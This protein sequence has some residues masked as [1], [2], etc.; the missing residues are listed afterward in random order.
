M[1]VTN[2]KAKRTKVDQIGENETWNMGAWSG[3]II[4]E[5]DEELEDKLEKAEQDKQLENIL[6]PY[7]SLWLK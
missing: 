1:D 3:R 6:N 7:S 4:Q 5:K 2:D